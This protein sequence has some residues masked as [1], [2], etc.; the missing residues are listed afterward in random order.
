[1]LDDGPVKL[2]RCQCEQMTN[3]YCDR[4]TGQD[5]HWSAQVMTRIYDIGTKYIIFCACDYPCNDGPTSVF[6][7]D[8]FP[9]EAEDSDFERDFH[10]M[11]GSLL[12]QSIACCLRRKVVAM[13][14]SKSV[15]AE[16]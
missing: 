7:V 9:K 8:W 14:K 13:N 1:M 11:K 5:Q 2:L 15:K 16:N 6:T 4:D 12:F 10:E 3:D